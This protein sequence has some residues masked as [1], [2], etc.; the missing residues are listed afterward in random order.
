MQ[1][2]ILIAI[3]VGG[4]VLTALTSDVTRVSEPGIQLRD[5]HPFLPASAG[6]WTGG[7][8]SGLTKEEREVL[9][10]DTDGA[11]RTYTDRNGRSIY[12]TV[13]LAGRDVTSIHR[14]EVCLTGQG[15]K[16]QGL[17]TEKIT[18]PQVAGGDLTVSRMN[19]ENTLHLTNG[20]T[21]KAYSIFV[22]WF[23][24]KDRTTPHHWQRIWWTTVDRVLRNR[25]HRWAYFLIN[26]IVT[27]DEAGPDPTATQ[28]AAM[29]LVGR[30][31]QDTYPQLAPQ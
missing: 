17:Q 16:L 21:T 12:C 5:G 28:E 1:L 3:L 11:R 20:Q 18:V 25:N 27:A 9:P 31:V 4:I 2:G 14:P 30:F 26:T 23:V 19:A 22:Y 8:Q 15:W 29:K 7:E 24:G 6:G 13:V 10:P